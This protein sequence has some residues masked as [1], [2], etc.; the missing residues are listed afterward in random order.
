VQTL[1]K[2]TRRAEVLADDAQCDA[3]EALMEE[4]LAAF[5]PEV[6]E[7]HGG[8]I[9]AG[10]VYAEV[11]RGRTDLNLRWAT[12]AYR[13]SLTLHGP[14]SER[15]RRAGNA[16]ATGYDAHGRYADAIAVRRDLVAIYT[17]LDGADAGTTLDARIC[18]ARSTHGAGH[19]QQAI[20][21]LLADWHDWSRTHGDDH[22]FGLLALTSVVELL[23]RCGR[24]QEA[25]ALLPHIQ[26]H[27]T[28]SRTPE[29]AAILVMIAMNAAN[30]PNAADHP[31]VC[32]GQP[33]DNAVLR[34]DRSH[35]VVHRRTRSR[36][37]RHASSRPEQP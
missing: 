36:P 25:N 21:A 10:T 13:A 1:A 27:A 23:N 20:T 26:A 28:W 18:L 11:S 19:C 34:T 35:R 30:D 5:N 16:L 12:Y 6:A 31:T 15:A 4:A 2:I 8:L 33:P 37:R 9:D 3:A 24:T 17:E 32:T 7:P 29:G 14:D 22:P